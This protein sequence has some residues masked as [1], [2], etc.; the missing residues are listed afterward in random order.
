MKEVSPENY[1][2]VIFDLGE[3]II[4]LDPQAIEDELYRASGKEL[5]YRELVFSSPL[6]QRYETGKISEG[7]FRKGMNELLSVSFSDEQ[8]DEIW[9]LMLGHI[10]VHR[11]K[12]MG[13]LMAEYQVMILSNTNPIHER[14]FDE[15]V[16]A[17]TAGKKMSDFVH[18]A[19]YSHKMGLRKPD[20]EIYLHVINS[21]TL[22]PHRTLFLDDRLDNVEAAKATGIDAVQVKYPDQIFEILPYD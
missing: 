5:D 6:M 16:S 10:P 7:D 15:L 20:E 1:D 2:T 12:L 17:Q 11:V 22:T 3:V 21:H 14:K 9:N 13:Q 4:D 18:F 19:H 8:F